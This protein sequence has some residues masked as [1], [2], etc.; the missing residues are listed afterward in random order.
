MNSFGADGPS[1]EDA[2]NAIHILLNHYQEQLVPSFSRHEEPEKQVVQF[3][4]LVRSPP[5]VEAALT[6]AESGFG[7]ETMMLN[8]PLFELMLDAYWA[9]TE[10]ELA[11][12]R[13]LA[14]ARYTQHLQREVVRRYPEL[15]IT[16]Q[17][18]LLPQEEVKAS[19]AIFGKHADR[20]WTGL[21]LKK[22]VDLFED[23][24]SDA[25]ES[26]RRQLWFCFDVLHDLNNGEIH[27]SSWSLSRAPRRIPTGEGDTYRL[28]FRVGPEPELAAF[29]L[30]FTW[31][32]FVQ[33][34]DLMHGVGGVSTDSLQEAA[35][36]GA[37]LLGIAATD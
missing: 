3:A 31:W 9:G 14:H 20:S 12:E 24:L 5:L 13:F 8:R 4:L 26:G 21:S 23:H 2:S 28:Q 22:R 1:L 25:G 10:P 27:P 16:P 30:G 18:G 37:E 15:G 33:T 34:L 32:V 7:R 29:A 36:A 19:A 6:L 35:D 11:D 17:G